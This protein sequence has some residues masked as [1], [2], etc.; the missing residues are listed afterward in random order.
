MSL[1]SWTTHRKCLNLCLRVYVQNWN[2]TSEEVRASFFFFLK[3]FVFMILISLSL[4]FTLTTLG[5]FCSL[6]CR[7]STKHFISQVLP[8]PFILDGFPRICFHHSNESSPTSDVT[9]VTTVLNSCL[10]TPWGTRPWFKLSNFDHCVVINMH[11]K[12]LC[13]C[14]SCGSPS[15]L[16]VSVL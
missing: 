14:W 8:V 16:C 1:T 15:L 13:L 10:N 6:V 11:W 12:V 4:S 3:A 5:F 9:G 7:K 2:C